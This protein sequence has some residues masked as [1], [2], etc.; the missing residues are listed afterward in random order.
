[1]FKKFYIMYIYIHFVSLLLLH[2]T[3]RIYEIRHNLSNKFL[4]VTTY[5]K[6]RLKVMKHS[7][8]LTKVYHFEDPHS[9]MAEFDYIHKRF[10]YCEHFL[11]LVHASAYIH[12]YVR[13]KK[14]LHFV[15]DKT[16]LN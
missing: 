3:F 6:Q 1:M 15:P 10:E 11:C 9:N 12:I 5:A 14:F 13:Q 7:L 8:E 4:V 16:K 2:S